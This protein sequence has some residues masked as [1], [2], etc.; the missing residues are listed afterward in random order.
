LDISGKELVVN[1]PEAEYQDIKGIICEAFSFK[2]PPST[3]HMN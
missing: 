2:A 3:L 1:S